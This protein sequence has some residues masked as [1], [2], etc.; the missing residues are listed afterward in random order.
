MCLYKCPSFYMD[1]YD[2]YVNSTCSMNFSIDPS[3]YDS[4]NTTW[5]S[6]WLAAKGFVWW[7]SVGSL[8]II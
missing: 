2:T 1:K 4:S 5:V 8:V 6:L 3:C 7:W